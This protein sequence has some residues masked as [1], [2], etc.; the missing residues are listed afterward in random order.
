MVHGLRM[1]SHLGPFSFNHREPGVTPRSTEAVTADTE[2]TE[3]VTSEDQT[4]ESN[5]DVMS[6]EDKAKLRAVV[7]KERERTRE[8]AKEAE[9]LRQRLAEIEATQQREADE[10]AAKDGEFEQLATKRAADLEKA[11]SEAT[12]LAE[13]RDALLAK[14]QAYEDRDREVLKVGVKDLPDDLKAFDPGEDAP[15]D[16]R[17]AWFEKARNIAGKRTTDPTRGNGRSPEPANGRDA[18][19]DEAARLQSQRQALRGF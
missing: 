13:E 7:R 11:K 9:T 1:V 14:V 3:D 4:A 5:D 12:T 16:A 17:M 8:A 2:Q 6:E 15:L 10:K 18:K 19:A